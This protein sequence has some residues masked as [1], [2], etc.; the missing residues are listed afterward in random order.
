[1]SDLGTADGGLQGPERPTLVARFLLILPD[2]APDH[3]PLWPG[4]R[5]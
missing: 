4:V 5:A 1:M 3:P 2:P